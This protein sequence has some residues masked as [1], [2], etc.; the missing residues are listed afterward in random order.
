MK[1]Y[2]P[3]YVYIIESEHLGL[4][5]IGK[6]EGTWEDGLDGYMGSSAYLNA[7]RSEFKEH[8]FVK[9][10]LQQFDN[11]ADATEFETEYIL[12]ARE[13]APDCVLNR[14]P[15]DHMVQWEHTGYGAIQPE[16]RH[17]LD[18]A[19]RKVRPIVL[20]DGEYKCLIMVKKSDG[21]AHAPCMP[22]R[23]LTPI[24]KYKTWSPELLVTY[25]NLP[26]GCYHFACVLEIGSRKNYRTLLLVEQFDTELDARKAGSRYAN[27]SSDDYRAEIDRLLT[28][29]K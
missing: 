3:T 18:A 5:Y 28:C 6:H 20:K 9:S 23:D 22:T 19:R 16:H 29:V 24:P 12:L 17:R 10:L 21:T 14:S 4:F 25:N 27:L 26:A 2:N 1:L 15:N 8:K 11:D 7:I 13:V